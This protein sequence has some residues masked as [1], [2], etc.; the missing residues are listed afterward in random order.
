[1]SHLL[2]TLAM[3]VSSTAA[4]RTEDGSVPS[5]A[6][7]LEGNRSADRDAIGIVREREDDYA[8]LVREHPSLALALQQRL[9]AELHRTLPFV[10]RHAS[11]MR[12]NMRA[13]TREAKKMWV[14]RLLPAPL[15]CSA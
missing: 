10:V 13:R 6:S 5:L 11:V 15:D 4:H 9:A 14:P 7:L 8:R 2:V 1:M 3:L 12:H